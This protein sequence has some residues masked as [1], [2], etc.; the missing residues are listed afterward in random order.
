[1]RRGD[2]RDRFERDAARRLRARA[3]AD[4]THGVAQLRRC[5]VVEQDRV[6]ARFEGGFD[7]AQ[8][9]ALDLYRQAGLL[10][11]ADGRGDAAAEP[12]VVVLDQDSVVQAEAMVRATARAHRAL[13]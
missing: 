2:L 8:R 4:E 10:C 7:V 5:H 12:Q 1:A 6:R 13:L 9:L 3:A 11:E